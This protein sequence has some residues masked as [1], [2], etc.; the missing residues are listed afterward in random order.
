[1]SLFLY[2]LNF[3]YIG[4]NLHVDLSLLKYQISKLDIILNSLIPKNNITLGLWNII[5]ISNKTFIKENKNT[6]NKYNNNYDNNKKVY[7]SI[8]CLKNDFM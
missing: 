3:H 2:Y 6:L 8:I 7:K 4:L 5:W 1:M